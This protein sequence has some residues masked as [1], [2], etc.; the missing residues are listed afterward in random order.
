MYP[1]DR[2]HIAYAAVAETHSYK[3]RSLL[4]ARF[5][6]WANAWESLEHGETEL[7]GMAERLG[8]TETQVVLKEDEEYPHLLR[9]IP[10]PPQGI[11]VRGRLPNYTK[12]VALVGTRKARESSRSRAEEWAAS[13]VRA[14]YVVVS[15]MAM[16]VDAAA[17]RGALAA[18]HDTRATVAVLATGADRCYPAHHQHLYDTILA[19]GSI[20]SEYAPGTTARP[21]FFLERNR[22]I[23]G[24]TQAT[25]V[26]EAPERSRALATAREALVANRD[27]LVA[28]GAVDDPQFAG[29]NTLLREGATIVR[30]IEDVLES[31][32]ATLPLP[33]KNLGAQAI[34]LHFNTPDEKIIAA[35]LK[36]HG[37]L[38]IDKIVAL[39]KLST[40]IVSRTLTM[41]TL[42]HA[43]KEKDNRFALVR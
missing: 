32:G 30:G 12:A 18:A 41:L 22:I 10:F 15:G 14:G 25:I 39:S 1:P 24:F 29:S 21:H 5:G 34:T 36:Q 35:L 38:T 8:Q 33:Q 26:I 43:V 42:R 4:H 19:G 11:F 6:S 37:A 2:E 31:L 17:H 20:V 13:L 28:P 3:K 23:A 9:E 16:G 40:H 27:V 7:T